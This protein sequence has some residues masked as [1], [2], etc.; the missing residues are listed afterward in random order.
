[1]K[2]MRVRKGLGNGCVGSYS[3][4]LSLNF[5]MYLKLLEKQYVKKQHGTAT[6]TDMKTSG[7]E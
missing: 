4:H 6:K 2:G 7:T 1:M 5:A 3:L